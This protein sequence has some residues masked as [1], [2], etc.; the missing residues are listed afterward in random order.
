MRRAVSRASPSP[1]TTA[2]PDA[3]SAGRQ[4]QLLGPTIPLLFGATIIFTRSYEQQQLSSG[5]V[6]A[7]CRHLPG[8]LTRRDPR[9]R[10]S[11]GVIARPDGEQAVSSPGTAHSGGRPE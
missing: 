4:V 5:N 2:R 3:G 10:E 7:S 9:P 11:V 1:A 8:R 6:P